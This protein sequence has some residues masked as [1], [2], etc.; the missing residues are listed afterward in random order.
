M[1]ATFIKI[2]DMARSYRYRLQSWL[3][4]L[5]IRWRKQ[6]DFSQ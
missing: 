3:F 4:I 2:A 6:W 1:P 5:T